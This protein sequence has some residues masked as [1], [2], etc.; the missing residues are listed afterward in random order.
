MSLIYYISKGKNIQK[1]PTSNHFLPLFTTLLITFCGFRVRIIYEINEISIN[2]RSTDD[3]C[4]F[5]E[6]LNLKLP[7]IDLSL[8]KQFGL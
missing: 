8:K 4:E 3:G 6:L 5:R 1:N 2:L 7:S